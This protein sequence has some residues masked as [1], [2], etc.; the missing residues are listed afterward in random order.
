MPTKYELAEYL[1]N[2]HTLLEAQERTGVQKSKVIVDE[3]N[4]I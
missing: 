2:L 1:V 4:R 3:Y